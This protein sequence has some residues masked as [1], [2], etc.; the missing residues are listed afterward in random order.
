MVDDGVGIMMEEAEETGDVLG[1]VCGLGEECTEIVDIIDTGE[2]ATGAV[3]LLRRLEIS[4][5]SSLL[6]SGCMFDLGRVLAVV[7]T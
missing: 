6:K 4:S 3:S 2:E 7:G 1:G 5:I